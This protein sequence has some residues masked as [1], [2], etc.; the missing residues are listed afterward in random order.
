MT[1]SELLEARLRG[2]L[3]SARDTLTESEPFYD[4]AT[5]ST[6]GDNR[7]EPRPAVFIK[8]DGSLVVNGFTGHAEAASCGHVIG[9]LEKL[10]GSVA[11]YE[12]RTVTL[13][14]R[15][16]VPEA[17]KRA[18]MFEELAEVWPWTQTPGSGCNAVA[19]PMMVGYLVALVRVKRAVNGAASLSHDAPVDRSDVI[20]WVA[21]HLEERQPGAGAQYRGM[22]AGTSP[23][24]FYKLEQQRREL[25][26]GEPVESPQVM[27]ARGLDSPCALMLGTAG[28][29]DVISSEQLA[30][31]YWASLPPSVRHARA[32][33]RDVER[34]ARGAEQQRLLERV[35]PLALANAKAEASEDARGTFAEGLRR[36]V[37]KLR[38][39]LHL[40]GAPPATEEEAL[41]LLDTINEDFASYVEKRG[42]AGATVAQEVREH[43]KRDANADTGTRWANW[44]AE[45]GAEPP[46]LV[47]LAVVVW[48]HETKREVTLRPALVMQVHDDVT[49]I[50]SRA[51]VFETRN[52]QRS[53]TFEDSDPIVLI[54]TVGGDVAAALVERGA[55]L[56]GSLAAHRALR[57]EVF[58]GHARVLRHEAD[59]RALRIEGGWSTFAHDVLGLTKKSDAE[60]LREIVHAQAAVVFRLPDGSTG[61]MLALHERPQQGRRRGSIEIVLGSMLLPFH[62]KTLATGADHRLVP[63]LRDLPPMVGRQ[64]E[65]GALA[66]LSM[67]V[68]RELRVKARELVTDGGV[69]ITPKRWEE[70]AY[71]SRLSLTLL[72]D[73]LERWL[74]DGDDA[75][76]LL[77]SPWKGGYTLGDAHEPER[78]FLVAAG[79]RSTVRSAA[80]QRSVQANNRKRNGRGGR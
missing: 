65:H 72:P 21:D 67:H 79:K 6:P 71:Q 12:A 20:A 52:G 54:P 9:E 74:R 35:V 56:F 38:P 33:F 47:A 73:V 16:L 51:S 26:Q 10:A 63:M 25:E 43:A 34:I 5:I 39:Q 8:D 11:A 66:T 27:W 36:N 42:D 28:P 41:A 1:L 15:I 7:G 13:A 48:L 37:A 31:F 23:A 60:R 45:P 22:S 57:W 76:A 68:L 50:Y 59:A 69:T 4:A 58:E 29:R 24:I 17:S 3:A 14:A 18:S 2:E 30:W 49:R 44:R 77:S 53:L 70:L 78:D 75:P 40:D 19:L 64:N 61:N 32:L 55:G 46:W 80:G 62:G